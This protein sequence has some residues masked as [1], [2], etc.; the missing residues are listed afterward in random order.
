[1]SS[2]LSGD[3]IILFSASYSTVSVAPIGTRGAPLSR[4]SSS[5]SCP[6]C[7]RPEPRELRP[8]FRWA[9]RHPSL[10]WILYNINNSLLSTTS[11]LWLVNKMDS[12]WPV[13]TSSAPHLYCSKKTENNQFYQLLKVFPIDVLLSSFQYKTSHVKCKNNQNSQKYT[14]LLN[15]K[16]RKIMSYRTEASYFLPLNEILTKLPSLMSSFLLSCSQWMY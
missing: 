2:E 7:S 10:Y 15:F 14:S 11:G 16:S 3:N 8:S 13:R 5:P 12:N 6:S 1:M 4:S 9:A